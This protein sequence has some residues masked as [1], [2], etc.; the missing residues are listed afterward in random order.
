M[1]LHFITVAMFATALTLSS[2]HLLLSVGQQAVAAS[3]AG[4]VPL[5]VADVDAEKY[6]SSSASGVFTCATARPG[7]SSPKTLLW[8]Y[9]NDDFCDCPDGSDEPGTAACAGAPLSK[10]SFYC[11]NE[12]FEGRFVASS[13]VSDGICDCCDGSDEAPGLCSD[14]CAADAA[15]AADLNRLAREKFEVGARERARLVSAAKE[16]LEQQRQELD[17]ARKLQKEASAAQSTAEQRSIALNEREELQRQTRKASAQSNAE[18][19]L[20]LH[21]LSPQR[22]RELVVQLVLETDVETLVKVQSLAENL[23]DLD[24]NATEVGCDP[25]IL[26][27]DAEEE[28]A[29]ASA[30]EG[31][32]EERGDSPEAEGDE[33]SEDV[34]DDEEEDLAKIEDIEGD[35]ANSAPQSSPQLRLRQKLQSAFEDAES[36]VEPEAQTLRDK[37]VELKKS[38]QSLEKAVKEKEDLV[39]NTDFGQDNV[40]FAIRDTCFQTE[41]HGYKWEFCPL[42]QMKQ[43]TTS[44]G[45]FARWENDYQTMIFEGGQRCWN[46]PARSAQIDFECGSASEL[47]SMDE[48]S[49]CVY[50]GRFTT[51]LLCVGDEQ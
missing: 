22:L 25:Q 6:L 35:D 39:E 42:K 34:D 36:F 30:V 3:T 14:T 31:E 51:P 48:P 44:L 45:N 41:L 18:V 38:T 11:R 47:V 23:H 43:D 49:K 32:A 9:V 15:R 16:G 10:P 21:L 8:S 19:R 13:R 17:R 5:G 1:I 29:I 37:L 28:A 27:Q 40:W 7:E 33:N 4:A 12:A 24:C 2:L 26:A 46:G 20:G 50:K